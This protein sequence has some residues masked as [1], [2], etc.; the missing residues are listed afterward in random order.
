MPQ[1]DTRN[2]RF[3]NRNKFFNYADIGS[4]GDR[5]QPNCRRCEFK[6]LECRTVQRRPI[7]RHGS[8][9]NLDANFREDQPWVNSRPRNWRA[10]RSN[11][12]SRNPSNLIVS[13]WQPDGSSP[14]QGSKS[15][16]E[17][18]ASGNSKPPNFESVGPNEVVQIESQQIESPPSDGAREVIYSPGSL[19]NSSRGSRSSGVD[20]GLGREEPYLTE[21]NNEIQLTETLKTLRECIA[22]CD[23]GHSQFFVE[24]N[25]TRV[26]SD[27]QESCLLRYFIEELS[28]WV[29]NFKWKNV[30][31]AN[32]TG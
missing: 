8:K 24:Q 31:L 20:N 19:S 11:L 21:P 28:P 30:L 10:A 17:R 26:S 13:N 1:K 14:I 2:V 4:I 6:G 5:R 29:G 12:M 25:P 32:N 7:F 3:V 16:E 15:A 18:N 22:P 27:L 23:Q 9:A